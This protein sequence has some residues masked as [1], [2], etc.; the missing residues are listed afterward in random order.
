MNGITQ[1]IADINSAVNGVVWGVPA[2]ALLIGTDIL[3]TVLTKLFRFRRFGHM[4]KNTI[5]GLFRRGTGIRESRDRHSIS[6]FQ[7]LCTAL[8]A[9]I[10][11]GVPGCP[12]FFRSYMTRNAEK[13]TCFYPAG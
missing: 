5:G 12:R 11:T 1:T 8:S 3:M 10:G 2:P 7:S 13:R 9:T 4:W 6:R